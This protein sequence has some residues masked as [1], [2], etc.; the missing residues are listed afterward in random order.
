M[1]VNHRQM[2]CQLISEYIGESLRK[3]RNLYAGNKFAKY[4]SWVR[5]SV[6]RNSDNITNEKVL[7][8]CACVLVT[9]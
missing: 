1:R 6:V 4:A 9:S 2:L 3:A 8:A 5:K 7:E